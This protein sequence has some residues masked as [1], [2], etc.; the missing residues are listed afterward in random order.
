MAKGVSFYLDEHVPKAVARGLR[1]RG[2]DVLTV[3]EAGLLGASDREHIA[4]AS[5]EGRVIFTLDDDFLRLHAES[6]DHAG[7]VHAAQGLSIGEIVHGLMLIRQIL[8][9]AE[10]RGHVEFL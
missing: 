2:V 8:T 5:E 7:I 3:A 1:L 10:M 9:P 6:T 4:R